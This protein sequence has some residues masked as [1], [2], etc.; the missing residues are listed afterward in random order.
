M[1]FLLGSNLGDRA[2]YLAIARKQIAQ[3]IAPLLRC[4]KIY[5]TEPWGPLQQPYFLNQALE[6][7]STRNPKAL[8]TSALA[9]EQRLGRGRRKRSAPRNIDIDLLYCGTEII[10]SPALTLPHPGIE[11][12]RFTLVPM[13]E[14]APTWL[15]PVLRRTQRQLLAACRDPLSVRPFEVY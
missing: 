8:L 3:Q 6:I 10:N 11:K 1:F 5:E 12:R 9:I 13:A 7:E 15:H 2:A 4:S 14:I